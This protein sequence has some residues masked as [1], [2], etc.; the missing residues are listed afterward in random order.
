MEDPPDADA[1]IEHWW[2]GVSSEGSGRHLKTENGSCASSGAQGGGFRFL[3]YIGPLEGEKRHSV[4][5]G[6]RIH[7]RNGGGPAPRVAWEDGA[8][9]RD[10]SGYGLRL[11]RGDRGDRPG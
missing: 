1:R 9:Y 3:R 6:E 4:G 7:D 11:R 10:P 8:G 5:P 2:R